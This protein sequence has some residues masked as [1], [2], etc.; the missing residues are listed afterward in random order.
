MGKSQTDLEYLIKHQPHLR[1]KWMLQEAV[2][3]GPRLVDF[4]DSLQS[5]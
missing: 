4:L 5:S 3:I 1:K 2:S